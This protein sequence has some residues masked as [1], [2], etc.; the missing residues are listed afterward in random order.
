MDIVM[1]RYI[2]SRLRL[3]KHTSAS[4]VQ[5]HFPRSSR[6]CRGT[7]TESFFYL[8]K[9]KLPF[10]LSAEHSEVYR[11]IFLILLAP[12]V[13]NA[14]IFSEWN[15]SKA[16]SALSKGEYSQAQET[17]RNMLV[18]EP[19]RPDLLYDMGIASFKNKE[20]AQ[21][22]AYFK[23]AAKLDNC[24]VHLKEQAL[25]NLAN[26]CVELNELSDAVVHYEHVLELN[27]QNE[28]AKHN[29]EVVKKMLEDQKSQ[30]KDQNQDNKQDQ[31]DKNQKNQ[32]QQQNNKENNQGGDQQKDQQDSSKGDDG[33]Q[34]ESDS[35][36]N[37]Q[38]DDK[39][40][41][42]S[43][44][45]NQQNNKQNNFGD[46]KDSREQSNRDGQQQK[47]E[48][49]GNE[50]GKK[51]SGQDKSKSDSKDVN[52]NMDADQ[53]P[54]KEEEKKSSPSQSA[55]DKNKTQDEGKSGV[56]DEKKDQRAQQQMAAAQPTNSEPELA[57]ED[58]WILQVLNRREHAEKK[59]NK[60]L[61]RANIDKKLGGQDGKNNW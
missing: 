19:T 12:T 1:V 42:G 28:Y 53:K 32:D 16:S 41:K 25:F 14:S 34:N 4:S 46:Q 31:K 47:K 48:Q 40:S 13:L 39:N 21:A 29:L 38:Q 45:K 17:M 22:A 43:S 15:Y 8:R 59:T 7:R 35:Q 51:E 24:S 52:K 6:A 44:G 37:K 10:V 2:F 11:R 50:R 61:M 18:D 33:K 27:D 57:P 56:G 54:Q 3:Q 60:Q 49:Q 26:A 5:A 9:I 58:K 23:D 20:Y 30:E 36:D 55:R